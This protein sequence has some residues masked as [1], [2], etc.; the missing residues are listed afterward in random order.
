M[1]R[2]GLAWWTAPWAEGYWE[3][4]GKEQHS[5]KVRT[6]STLVTCTGGSGSKTSTANHRRPLAFWNRPCGRA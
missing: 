6:P 1:V 3:K 2:S 4:F 5:K